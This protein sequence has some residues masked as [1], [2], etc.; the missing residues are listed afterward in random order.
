M[1]APF[2]SRSRWSSAAFPVCRYVHGGVSVSG[3]SCQLRPPFLPNHRC[4]LD[5]GHPSCNFTFDATSRALGLSQ[6][7]RVPAGGSVTFASCG[8]YM[9]QGVVTSPTCFEVS[10]L[11]ALPYL[12][13]GGMHANYAMGFWFRSI[14]QGVA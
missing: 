7:R 5:N 6:T 1:R 9:D 14:V 10:A 2:C 12:P 13:A 4:I 8:V 3:A 11:Q